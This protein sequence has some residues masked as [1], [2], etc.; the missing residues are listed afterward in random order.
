MGDVHA[1]FM[2][3]AQPDIIRAA[4]KDEFYRQ[5]RRGARRSRCASAR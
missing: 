2:P 4:E 3:A 1:T 5:A